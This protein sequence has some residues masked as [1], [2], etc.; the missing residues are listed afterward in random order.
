MEIEP[1][2]NLTLI[3]KKSTAWIRIRKSF[4]SKYQLKYAGLE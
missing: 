4:K 2:R 1:P 3:Y